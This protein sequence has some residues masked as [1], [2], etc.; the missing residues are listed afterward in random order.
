MIRFLPRG[1]YRK[2]V[3]DVY[4]DTIDGTTDACTLKH[5]YWIWKKKMSNLKII[6]NGSD[7]CDECTTLQK[8]NI[9]STTIVSALQHHRDLAQR[10]RE[11]YSKKC[12]EAPLHLTFDFAQSVHIPY[13]LRQLGW[14][15]FKIGV[16]ARLFGVCCEKTKK[17]VNYVLPEGS[18][19]C[20]ERGSRKGSNLV[21][22][23]M[24]NYIQVYNNHP[25]LSLNADSC[26]GQNKNRFV[27]FYLMWRVIIG[28]NTAIKL[29]FM[30]PEHTKS[31]VDDL[32]G[33]F[34]AYMLHHDVSSPDD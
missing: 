3:Y 27:F 28:L 26:S 31:T 11:F 25:S 4:K 23:L 6:K 33:V 2:H 30:V 21:I 17:Q 14:Y 7:F 12:E 16:V 19:P 5:F 24:H 9:S 22:L 8:L 32:F 18:Y 34:K 29:C 15:F 10:E 1:T 13:F 20:K